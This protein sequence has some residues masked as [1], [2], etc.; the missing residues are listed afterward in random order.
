MGLFRSTCEIK[1]QIQLEDEKSVLEEEKQILAHKVEKCKTLKPSH[2]FSSWPA[3]NIHKN[4]VKIVSPRADK[5]GAVSISEIS[6]S[7]LL[8]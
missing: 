3:Y 5:I 1:S 2:T 4:K 8:V 7:Q 6:T